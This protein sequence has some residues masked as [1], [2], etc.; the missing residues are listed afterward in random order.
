MMTNIVVI[1]E[2]KGYTTNVVLQTVP[3]NIHQN[4]YIGYNSIETVDYCRID[5]LNP[6][7]KWKEF[8][9]AGYQDYPAP[10]SDQFY[11]CHR[12]IEM[13]TPGNSPF[14]VSWT[15]SAKDLL[16]LSSLDL[17]C[18][19]PVDTFFFT[20]SVPTEMNF[21]YHPINVERIASLKADSSVSETEVTYTFVVTTRPARTLYLPNEYYLPDTDPAI[22]VIITPSEYKGK[23]T[24]YLN[25]YFTEKMVPNGNL[26]PESQL[27]FDRACNGILDKDSITDRLFRFVRDEIHYVIF[28]IGYGAF[29]PKDV[30]AI[31]KSRQGDCK[32]MAFLLCQALNYKGIHANVALVG[33]VT[34]WT[35][36]TF[37]SLSSGDHMIC[38]IQKTNGW[39]FLD[40][41]IKYTNA[42]TS[43]LST[44]GRMAFIIGENGGLFA[45]VPLVP[46]EYNKETY[47]F[48]LTQKKDTLTGQFIYTVKG[49][50]AARLFGSISSVDPEKRLILI[51]RLLSVK[52][53][54]VT[55]LPDKLV[56]T[57]DSIQ[58]TGN[59]GIAKSAFHTIKGNGLM[60][61]EILPK[62]LEK[63]ITD[64][65]PNDILLLHTL[66]K[67]VSIQITMNAPV[68][69]IGLKSSAY[70]KDKYLFRLEG[71][72]NNSTVNIRYLFSY[73][74]AVIRKSNFAAYNEF[75]AYLSKLFSNVVTISQ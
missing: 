25:R 56:L 27:I 48:T 12:V 26:S 28:N 66:S 75:E 42:A 31:L 70:Q 23:E 18:H 63:I 5:F 69:G 60:S 58:V 50:P 24:E 57:Y 17:T 73:D 30:N 61:L 55:Y 32:D 1:G 15:C 44:Q 40:P 13:N 71:S 7:G 36:S 14:Q 33:T 67:E 19:Y 68:K 54:Y 8:K 3:D 46:A 38:A 51:S 72:Q 10:Y 45:R 2:K 62:P 64:Q 21:A 37:P 22:Q 35:E 52:Q 29:I 53:K 34:H 43:C 6:N 11:S 74:D 20:V 65:I 9:G 47:S 49:L 16:L 4:F 41:T 59:V 39:V